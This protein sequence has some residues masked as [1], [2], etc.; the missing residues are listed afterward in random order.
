[1]FKAKGTDPIKE[2]F[3]ELDGGLCLTNS[4][5]SCTFIQT[6]PN[7]R[8]MECPESQGWS[9]PAQG[10]AQHHPQES[11]CESFVQRLLELCQAWCWNC[12]SAQS[13]SGEES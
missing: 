5:A 6:F 10:P 3:T 8:I 11:E 1:M 4:L 2:L 9:S 12:Y 7:H 13:P